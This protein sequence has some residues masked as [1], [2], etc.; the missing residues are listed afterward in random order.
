MKKI[1]YVRFSSVSQNGERQ[2]INAEKYDDVYE[3]CVSGTIAFSSRPVGKK[4][5]VSP[6][7]STLTTRRCRKIKERTIVLYSSVSGVSK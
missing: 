4:L 2:T 3:E 1:L 5:D 7:S 6:L